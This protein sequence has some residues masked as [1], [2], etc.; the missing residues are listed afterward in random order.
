MAGR[1]SPATAAAARQLA[2]ESVARAAGGVTVAVARDALER[3][4]A[5]GRV[6]VQRAAAGDDVDRARRRHAVERELPAKQARPSRRGPP[7]S[8][9]RC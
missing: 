9:L 7:A 1:G 8:G 5:A 6:A 4:P 3:A 2:I